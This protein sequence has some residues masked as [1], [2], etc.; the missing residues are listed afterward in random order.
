MCLFIGTCHWVCKHTC[1]EVYLFC[2]ELRRQLN[3][4]TDEAERE[5]YLL[6]FD[7]GCPGCNPYTNMTGAILPLGPDGLPCEGQRDSNVVKWVMDMLECCPI[8]SGR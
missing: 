5:S 7:A 1:F 8:C 6:P 2:D 4:I 3:R